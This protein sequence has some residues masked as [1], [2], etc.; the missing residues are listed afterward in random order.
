MDRFRFAAEYQDIH[1]PS[2]TFAFHAFTGEKKRELVEA[3]DLKSISQHAGVIPNPRTGEDLLPSTGLG[4]LEDPD[5]PLRIL[6]AVE[7]GAIGLEG[8]PIADPDESRW[9]LAMESQGVTHHDD[10][11]RQSG[12]SWGFGKAAFAIGSK[13][14]TV[15]AYSRFADGGDGVTTRLGGY[16]YQQKHRLDDVPYSGFAQ[17]GVTSGDGVNPHITPYQNERAD[18]IAALLGMKREIDGTVNDLG[19]T[20]MIVDPA[21]EPEDLRFSLE[22]YWWPTIL[23]ETLDINVIDYDGTDLP[24]RPKRRERSDLK[25]F[26][27]A[28]NLLRKRSMPVDEYQKLVP[29]QRLGG[30]ENF[31]LGSLALTADPETC[32]LRRVDDESEERASRIALV[33]QRGMV[34]NY[35]RLYLNRPPFVD[36]VLLTHE[37]IEQVLAKIEPKE[38]N[39]WWLSDSTRTMSIWTQSWKDIVQA[40]YQRTYQH[41]GTF[42]GLLNADAEEDEVTMG[43]LGRKL[44]QVLRHRSNRGG[45]QRPPSTGRAPASMSIPERK[46][47]RERRNDGGVVYEQPVSVRLIDEVEAPSVPARIQVRF[48]FEEDTGA[49]GDRIEMEYAQVPPGWSVIDGLLSGD[50]T[51]AGVEFVARTA[52]VYGPFR[53]LIDGEVQVDHPRIAAR[54]SNNG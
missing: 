30:E 27:E 12:G 10:T 38:H 49:V 25:P 2:L 14:A 39:R 1:E 34:V 41:V 46:V 8:D 33:R 5:E 18:E 50:L 54:E 24:P 23:D 40:L 22:S 16:V 45:T 36:G 9:Y 32:F 19:T 52:P 51:K 43:R 53:V 6:Y 29:F 37:D 13:I 35:E 3:L 26:L 21:L 44:G 42:R 7:R 11:D 48:N 31:E 20:F 28:W 47:K 15:V 17:F 4:V